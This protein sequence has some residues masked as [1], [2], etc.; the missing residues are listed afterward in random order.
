MKYFFPLI[1]LAQAVAAAPQGVLVVKGS[2]V[3]GIEKKVGSRAG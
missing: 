1:L 2:D 3:A